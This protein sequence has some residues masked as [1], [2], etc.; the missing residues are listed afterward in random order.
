MHASTRSLLAVRECTSNHFTFACPLIGERARRARHS[1]V[2]SIEN[3]DNS[4]YIHMSHLSF[5][6]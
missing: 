4:T 3:R 5:D 6:L 2:R 1:Q